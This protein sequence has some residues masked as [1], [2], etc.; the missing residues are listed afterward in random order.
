[1][2]AI[3]GPPR[4]PARTIGRPAPLGRWTQ[5]R[6]NSSAVNR[7]LVSGVISFPPVLPGIL[8]HVLLHHKALTP[9]AWICSSGSPATANA[10]EPHPLPWPQGGSR[11]S[12]SPSRLAIRR[13]FPGPSLRLLIAS[14]SAV[15]GAGEAPA[16]DGEEI[17]AEGGKAS[18]AGSSTAVEAPGFRRRSNARGFSSTRGTRSRTAEAS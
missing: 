10:A 5:S 7:C 12:P 17:G 3:R 15:T 14:D 16:V 18:A 9:T 11:R 13:S 4:G 1:M 6:Q 8:S 2:V